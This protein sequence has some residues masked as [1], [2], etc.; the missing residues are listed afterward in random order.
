MD[1]FSFFKKIPPLVSLAPVIPG[2]EISLQKM[3]LGEKSNVVIPPELGYGS[4]EIPNVIPANSSL[5]F[6]IELVNIYKPVRKVELPP[7][8]DHG[9]SCGHSH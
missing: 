7:P 1:T 4:Q 8:H 3:S 9:A 5:H 2:W 6:E